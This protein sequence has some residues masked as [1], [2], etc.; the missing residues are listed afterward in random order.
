MAKRGQT[1]GLPKATPAKPTAAGAPAQ[2]R[3]QPRL[4]H[5]YKTKAER[6]AVVQRYIILGTAVV[7][8]IAVVILIA[9]ILID[10]LVVPG[11]AAAVVNGETI[12][13]GEF[14]SRV[15]LE[16]ALINN[17]LNQAVVTAQ[18]LGMS[19]DELTNFL[20]SQPPYSTWLNEIQVSDQ[21][22]NRVL[23]EIIE[24]HLIRQRA[25]QLGVSVSEEDVQAKI[26]EFFDYDPNAGLTA[27]TA[28]TAPTETPT[29]FVSPTPTNTPTVT[30]TAELTATATFTPFPSATPTTTP[31]ATQRAETFNTTR[32]EFYAYLR[33][34]AGLSDADINRFFESLALRDA[35]RDQVTAE[36]AQTAPFVNVR[37]IVVESEERAQ[38]IISAL[39]AGE[40]F[41][42]LAQTASSD[43]SNT[44]G[45]ELG[46]QQLS[47][48]DA[49]PGEDFTDAIANAEIGALVGP[50]QSTAGYHVAQVRGRE[51]RE[52][53]DTE[54]EQARDAAFE[55]YVEDLRE[56]NSANI[57]IFDTW[58]DNVPENPRFALT[59]S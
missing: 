41:A 40:S 27:P 4:L 50:I 37:Q 56:T 7:V 15:R 52:L 51:D 22:G 44:Q 16:R 1:G 23:N 6:E 59:L 53:T 2:K 48:F 31:D 34:Q 10:Q 12:T 46:W 58:L 26:N 38:E 24:D 43:A 8:G 54:Y 13:I 29:P 47:S 11:Q 21:L 20:S 19:N 32:S 33:S 28:T 30:P 57:Q 14:Q 25:A 17:Q 3:N 9:A 55:R 36:Q 49:A 42:A 45:G 39:E 35:L 18:S 5:E